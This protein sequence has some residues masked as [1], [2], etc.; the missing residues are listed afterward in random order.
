MNRIHN[1]LQNVTGDDLVDLY[2]QK[3]YPV[4]DK[5]F[6]PNFFGVRSND[7]IPNKF[8]DVVGVFF[9]TEDGGYEVRLYDATTDPGLYWLKNPS[10]NLGTAILKP[11]SY[12]S[13]KLGMHQGKYEAI[14]QQGG[15][16]T[17]YRDGN[18]DSILNKEDA[19]GGETSG[20]FGINIHRANATGTSVQV[21][22]WSAGCQVVANYKDFDDL[23]QTAKRAAEMYG[24]NSIFRYSLF[25]E[26]D[27][28][29]MA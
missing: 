20:Y 15:E 14:V 9:L 3:G 17:V 13:Y 11:G 10:N 19:S 21:D 29:N 18:R 1:F 6:Y 12:R 4:S 28:A 23:L 8:D 2:N 22:K 5:P 24:N 7:E 16:V 27:F 26:D 25:V